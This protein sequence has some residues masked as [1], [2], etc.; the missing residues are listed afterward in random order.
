MPTTEG[1]CPAENSVH[2]AKHRPCSVQLPPQVLLLPAG[3][4]PFWGA[5]LVEKGTG[6][7]A[8]VPIPAGEFR[9]LWQGK[10]SLAVPR[11]RASCA[12]CHARRSEAR[13][14]CRG[15]SLPLST[16]PLLLPGPEDKVLEPP[17]ARGE[18]GGRA[19]GAAARG[20]PHAVREP[21]LGSPPASPS[22]NNNMFGWLL[23]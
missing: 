9:A 19:Q 13:V 14:A 17:R 22:S 20:P 8:R 2:L 5:A 1:I 3:K 15:G 16:C 11:K 6:K 21:L 12:C 18:A 7:D 10:A 4:A 23:T